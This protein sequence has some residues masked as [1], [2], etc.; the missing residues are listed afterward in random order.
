MGIQSG[1]WGRRTWEVTPGGGQMTG[2]QG[3]QEWVAPSK[4]LLGPRTAG[5]RR[6]AGEFVTIQETEPA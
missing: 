6:R 4:M 5:P 2:V 3:G 1:G